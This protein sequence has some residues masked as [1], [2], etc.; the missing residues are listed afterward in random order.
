ML[1]FFFLNWVSIF[2]LLLIFSGNFMW[3]CKLLYGFSNLGKIYC[4]VFIMVIL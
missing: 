3:G 1:F 4:V 2:V